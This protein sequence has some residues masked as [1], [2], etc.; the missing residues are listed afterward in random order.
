MKGHPCQQRRNEW[1]MIVLIEFACSGHKKAF[2]KW[3]DAWF[4][5]NKIF[6]S[7]VEQF[8]NDFHWWLWHLLNHWQIASLNTKNGYSR[9]AIYISLGLGQ[10][11][12]Y[13]Y[14]DDMQWMII[15]LIKIICFLQSWRPQLPFNTICPFWRRFL[16]NNWNILLPKCSLKYWTC[17][18]SQNNI[19][20]F[21]DNTVYTIAS[22]TAVT[23]RKSSSD[24]A[25]K[26]AY[27]LLNFHLWIKS[28]SF[29]VWVRYFV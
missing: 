10:A 2:T 25:F 15:E 28:T 21:H 26:N 12:P 23:M 22:S 13:P 9:Q 17:V 11:N 27:D 29:N 19:V 5:M 24:Y 20:K 3:N 6:R 1:S 8:A 14:H 18:G 16:A 7:L 4:T